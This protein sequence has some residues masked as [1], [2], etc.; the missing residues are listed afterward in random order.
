MDVIIQSQIKS[1]LCRALQSIPTN[2]NN[3]LPGIPDNTPPFSK[4]SVT[5]QPT[6]DTGSNLNG[7]QVFKIPQNGRLTNVYLKYRMF[8]HKDD[9]NVT[10]RHDSDNVFSFGHGIETIQLR[11]HNNVIQTIP[12][13]AIPFENASV[14]R[15]EQELKHVMQGMAGY[16]GAVASPLSYL[17]ESRMN[18][19]AFNASISVTDSEITSRQLQLTV[20]D[21]LVRV[22]LSSTF[23]LK[24]NLQTRMM[25]DLELVVKTKMGVT[26]YTG[27]E[28]TDTTPFDKVDRHEISM[29]AEFINFHEN[30]EE[31]IRNE[32]FKP[33]VP[34]TMLQSDYDKFTAKFIR[35]ESSGVSATNL[36]YEVPLTT[37]A[38]ATDIFVV[39]KITPDNFG[40]EAF[41]SI[42][43]S[44]MSFRLLAC[45]ET[46]LEGN[47]FELE[48]MESRQH[49][50]VS[51]QYQN[52]G[53][54]PLRWS[55]NGSRIRLGLNNTDEYFDG[56][57]SFQSLIEPKLEIRITVVNTAAPGLA[58]DKGG[59]E[60]INLK[61]NPERVEFDVVVKRKVLLRI[62]GN[63]GKISKS[64][65]S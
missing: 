62:D 65:E 34:A 20:W 16:E 48:G 8:G 14:C 39:P 29:V 47:R 38:L 54:L 36:Y 30:V 23:Y 33:D 42:R 43:Q 25:E 24:D 10:L 40:Y 60:T 19:P 51:R 1:P 57:I 6:V 53:V 2:S 50:T 44:A 4:T 11:T 35:S 41:H 13:A 28:V 32:M 15:S 45:G 61:T 56:G 31:V 63:T 27:T 58:A 5:V 49:S 55:Q 17:Q 3:F 52:S 64:L 7:V 22:P 21:F 12:A 26:Q 59:D 9:S 46:L 37:D 18:L